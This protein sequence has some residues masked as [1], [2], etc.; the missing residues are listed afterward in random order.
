MLRRWRMVGYTQGLSGAAPYSLGHHS[1]VWLKSAGSMYCRP[2][3][4]CGY[5][6]LVMDVA[7]IQG[8]MAVPGATETGG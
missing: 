3:V 7:A 2:A 5:V 6:V 8:G 4:Q 1:S